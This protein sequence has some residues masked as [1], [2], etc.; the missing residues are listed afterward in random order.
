MPTGMGLVALIRINTR[1]WGSEE[2]RAVLDW[3]TVMTYN[4]F[5]ERKQNF[6]T[7]VEV[8]FK[9]KT[10]ISISK[11]AISEKYVGHL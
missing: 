8:K 7:C 3:F 9:I 1:R 10:I 6:Q 5:Q 11:T 4:L 2:N